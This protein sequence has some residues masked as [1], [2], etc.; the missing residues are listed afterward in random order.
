MGVS[1]LSLYSTTFRPLTFEFPFFSRSKLQL[2]TSLSRR[3][4]IK[5]HKLS[6]PNSCC[7]SSLFCNTFIITRHLLF[8]EN[9][10]KWNDFNVCAVRGLSWPAIPFLQPTCTHDRPIL[11]SFDSDLLSS[12]VFRS[13]LL[14]LRYFPFLLRLSPLPEPSRIA[15]QLSIWL[16]S[17]NLR[18]SILSSPLAQNRRSRTEYSWIVEIEGAA[19]LLET[20]S[21]ILHFLNLQLLSVLWF[22][23]VSLT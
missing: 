15:K 14:L 7:N 13:F 9:W 19:P 23:S 11:S 5:N 17:S 4:K 2:F 3:N 10:S 8:N 16:D 22:S 18:P 6:K 21:R 12:L 20:S 1:W